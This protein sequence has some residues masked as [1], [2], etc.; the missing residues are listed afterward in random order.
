MGFISMAQDKLLKGVVAFTYQASGWQETYNLRE[1][2]YDSAIQRMIRLTK[3][4]TAWMGKGVKITFSRVISAGGERD[5]AIVP[6]LYPLEQHAVVLANTTYRHDE[7]ND[8]FTALMFRCQTPGGKWVNRFFRG[9]GDNYIVDT[10]I[11]TIPDA[12]T[13]LALPADQVNPDTS[14]SPLNLLRGFLA[15]VRDFTVRAKK[16]GPSAW[17]VED[18]NGLA[19]RRVGKHNTGRPFGM[20]RGRASVA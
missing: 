15:Y 6:L 13:P 20:F 14:M 17:E 9:I 4:R 11:D 5:A 10:E 7:P 18:F 1:T 16:T 12:Y 19:F 2:T 8:P 3:L